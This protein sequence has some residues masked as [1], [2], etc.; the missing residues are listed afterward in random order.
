MITNIYFCV[1]IFELVEKCL[2][3]FLSL[4]QYLENTVFYSQLVDDIRYGKKWRLF[5]FRTSVAS[6]WTRAGTNLQSC[7]V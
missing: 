2:W 5:E 1:N 6:D 7:M 4:S 3:F